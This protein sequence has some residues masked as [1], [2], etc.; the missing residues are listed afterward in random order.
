MKCEFWPVSRILL[1]L[2]INRHSLMS[3]VARYGKLHKIQIIIFS[4]VMEYADD[5]DVF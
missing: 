4:I 1:L 3:Q 5:G 2:D